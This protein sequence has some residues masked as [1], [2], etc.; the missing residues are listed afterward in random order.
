MEAAVLTKNGG[1]PEAAAAAA[2]ATG[3]GAAARPEGE[4]AEPLLDVVFLHGLCGGPYKTWRVADG[5]A[6]T[7]V[8]SGLAEPPDT[9][10]AGTCWP[11][12]WL[13]HDLPGLRMITTKYK[14]NLTEWTGATLPLPE[15]SSILLQKLVAAGVGD[16]PVV[17]VTHSMGGLIAKQMLVYAE[18]DPAFA[19]LARQTR[20]VVFY[21]CPHF[22][23]RLADMPWRMGYVLRPAPS[24]GDLRTELP[25]LH[26]L[27]RRLKQF[28]QSGQVDVLSY[29]ETKVTPLVEAYGRIALRMEVV[30]LESAYPGFGTII[31][32]EGTDHVNACKPEG[33]GDLA[34][35]KTLDFLKRIHRVALEER[36]RRAAAA[37]AAAGRQ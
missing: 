23:S 14:T 7:A 26:E 1:P 25:R 22:G 15:V 19:A 2:A 17:F 16:R 31:V 6:P 33:R 3:G 10:V 28:V 27:N 9:G 11:T 4:G 24:V 37:A 18:E 30:P 13:A 34:Y 36:E 20:G 35:T 5:A 8:V 12:Q 21:S 32:L 29:A